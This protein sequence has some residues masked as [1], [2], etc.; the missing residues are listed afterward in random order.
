MK[1][2]LFCL[3]IG[4]AITLEASEL[5]IERLTWAGVRFV[6]PQTTLLV[7]AVGQDLWDGNAPE[8]LVPVVADT[9]RRYAL[10]TH[11]HNDHFDPV[12]LQA[13]LGEK[14]YVIVHED[15]ATY[16][17]SRGFKVIPAQFY[18]PVS[19]GGFHMTVVPAVDGFGDNQV[20]WV[21]AY[22][23]KRYFHGGDTLWHGKWA[24][25]GNQFGPFEAAFL[26][27]NG[28]RVNTGYLPLSSMVMTPTNAV[29]AASLL[30]AKLLVPIHFG[31]NDP[32]NYIEV[33]E[34]LKTLKQI[35]EK[36][37]VH[38]Q[39]LKPGEKFKPLGTQ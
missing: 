21:I 5:E 6:T 16:I 7:D 15:D 10:I 4:F 33:K 24:E 18:K 38:V 20:N 8:G 34:P 3:L 13:V 29:D 17:A 36:Q 23:G 2:V 12:T 39:H 25:Y 22:N 1:K 32:P 11:I 26:P 27:I 37:K 28:A 35:A 9:R 19:R 31:L 30:K 14:G